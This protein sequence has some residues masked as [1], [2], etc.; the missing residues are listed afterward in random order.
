MCLPFLGC[1]FGPGSCCCCAVCPSFRNSILTRIN[2]GLM[3]L[4]A[5]VICAILLSPGIGQLFE[6]VS[7]TLD[8]AGEYVRQAVTQCECCCSVW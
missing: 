4:V 8:I 3:L 6:T 2:Y 7:A 5:T 1:F